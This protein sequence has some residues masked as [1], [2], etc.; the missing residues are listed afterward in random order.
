[1]DLDID[2]KDI[3][4]IKEE[5]TVK[6]ELYLPIDFVLKKLGLNLNK[7]DILRIEDRHNYSVELEDDDS[8]DFPVAGI[9]IT[10]KPGSANFKRIEKK[11]NNDLPAEEK[12]K[13]NRNHNRRILKARKKE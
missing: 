7:N 13:K 6:K 1:M 5:I 2:G 10:T 4:K 8:L 12:E 9:I 3:D 11:T